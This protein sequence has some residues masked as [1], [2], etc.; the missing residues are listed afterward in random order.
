MAEALALKVIPSFVQGVIGSNLSNLSSKEVVLLLGVR[1][2]ITYIIVEL[3]MIKAFLRSAEEKQETDS[4]AREWVRLVR[5]VSLDM[6]NC[7]DKFKIYLNRRPNRPRSTMKAF[8]KSAEESQETDSM[9]RMWVQRVRKVSVDLENCLGKFKFY[10]KRLS[11]S[12]FLDCLGYYLQ[13]LCTI[14]V[15]H[16]I[17]AEIQDLKYRIAQIS[18]CRL[19]YGITAIASS[20]YNASS[21]TGPCFIDHRLGALVMQEVQL[22]GI[23]EPRKKLKNLLIRDDQQRRIIS[24]LGMGGL[25]KTTLTKRVYED[26]QVGEYFECRAWIAIS[27]SFNLNALLRDIIKQVTPRGH[28]IESVEDFDNMQSKAYLIKQLEELLQNRCYIIVLDDIWSIDAWE[29]I[30]HALPENNNR[31][32]VIVT[33]R[34]EEVAKHCCADAGV[35]D[36]VYKLPLLSKENSIELFQKR[37][38]GPDKHCPEHLENV[39]NDIVAKC[40]CLPLAIVAMASVLKGMTTLGD[41]QQWTNLLNNLPSMLETNASLEGM[42]QVLLLSYDYLPYLLKPCFL[43]LSIFP[44]DHLIKRKKLIKLWVAEGLVSNQY[45]MSAEVVAEYYFNEL[46]SRSLILPSEVGWNGKVK[47]CRIHDIMLEILIFKSMEENMVSIHGKQSR[48]TLEAKNVIRRLSLQGESNQIRV[49]LDDVDL[50]L[51]TSLSIYGYQKISDL[52]PRFRLLRVLVLEKYYFSCTEE[53]YSFLRNLSKLRHLRYLSHLN[54]KGNER[55]SKSLS[56]SLSKLQNLVTLDLGGFS[57]YRLC[58]SIAKL[59]QLRHLRVHH[60][61]MEPGVLRNLKNLKT[62]CGLHIHK[63]EEAEELGYL[64]QLTK[65]YINVFSSPKMNSSLCA[66]LEKLSGS[67]LSLHINVI[68]EQSEIFNLNMK[69]PPSLLQ[70]LQITTNIKI[71][72]WV[73]SLSNLAKLLLQVEKTDDLEVIKTLPN[74]RYLMISGFLN[75][76]VKLLFSTRGFQTLKILEISRMFR[77]EFQMDSMPVLQKIVFSYVAK[78]KRVIGIGFLP[79][80]EEIQLYFVSKRL[81][82]ELKLEAEKHKNNP[83]LMASNVEDWN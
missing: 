71:P 63:I 60:S 42:K 69:N 50:S 31:S 48:T 2:E 27:Q 39:T 30:K 26:L 82:E 55:L 7:M 44:E 77:V 80:L 66:S 47:S 24:V 9:A 18:D 29:S 25:G 79:C 12:N 73:G 20:S 37:V 17:A 81:V 1:K 46:I 3:Q 33:T 52:L 28:K 10:L 62:L 43:Y 57:S 67:L 56:K 6:E 36:Y 19:R 75:R 22:V 76:S 11:N 61:T 83:N 74:L 70:N 41:H 40:G 53:I 58:S 51:V 72:C 16:E 4:L 34:I 35:A 78:L 15:R 54:L 23:D 49:I 32:R 68:A 65:L 59:K 5:E 21:S 45:A 8:L 38:F 14:H 64:T 13:S